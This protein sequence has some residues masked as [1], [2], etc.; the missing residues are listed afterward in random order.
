VEARNGVVGS[1]PERDTDGR[2]VAWGCQF[3][4]AALVAHHDEVMPQDRYEL[5][6]LGRRE[7]VNAELE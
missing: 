5:A 2:V 4:L 6:V 7:I 3:V 1:C